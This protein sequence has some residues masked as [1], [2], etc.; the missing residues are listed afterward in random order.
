MSKSPY[1]INAKVLGIGVAVITNTSGFCPF[2]TIVVRCF[3]PNLCCSSVTTNPN[4]LN[5]TFS[6]KSA[7]V[8]IKI[9]IFPSLNLSNISSF[10]FL[11]MLETNSSHV[12]PNLSSISLKL[13]KC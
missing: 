2:S 8:P 5:I 9:S 6:S 3:T 13:S 10:F 11:V 4:L 7:C 1:K 12:I